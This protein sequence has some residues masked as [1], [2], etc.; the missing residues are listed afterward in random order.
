LSREVIGTA[1]H[2]EIYQSLPSDVD[3]VQKALMEGK[4]VQSSTPFGKALTE[5]TKRLAGPLPE[6]PEKPK[7]AGGFG[8]L[9]GLFSRPSK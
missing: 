8:G 2:T 3:G 1:L 5:L 7:K 4:P 6:A 9:L